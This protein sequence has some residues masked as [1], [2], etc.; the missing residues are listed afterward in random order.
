MVIQ[1]SFLHR[2]VIMNQIVKSNLKRTKE[3]IIQINIPRDSQSGLGALFGDHLL[4]VLVLQ[5]F[6]TLKYFSCG[7]DDNLLSFLKT[8]EDYTLTFNLSNSYQMCFSVK[9]AKDLR[10][11]RD[12]LLNEFKMKQFKYE[13]YW[14]N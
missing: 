10:V 5:K 9:T 13:E 1:F 12:F 7:V 14:K 4:V 8:F 3:Y 6:G 2:R 11:F